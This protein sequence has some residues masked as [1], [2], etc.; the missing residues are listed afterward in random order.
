M[1]KNSHGIMKDS[2]LSVGIIQASDLKPTDFGGKWDPFCVIEVGEQE[3]E[4]TVKSNTLNP[5]WNENFNFS[6]QTGK[7][8][9]QIT[10]LDRNKDQENA[11][12]GRMQVKVSDFSDQKW[13]DLWFDL[14][15]EEDGD[16]TGGK[17]RIN[18]SLWW[19]HSKED[20]LKE[21]IYGCDDDIKVLEENLIYYDNRVQLMEIPMSEVKIKP[22]AKLGNNPKPDISTQNVSLNKSKGPDAT[23]EADLG[24]T[25]LAKLVGTVLENER[26]W[27]LMVENTSN[28]L[29]IKLGF[30]ETPW[31]ILFRISMYSYI[32]MT[33]FWWFY[34]PDFLNITVCSIM[35]Y[36]FANPMQMRQWHI[37]L[38][39]FGIFITWIFDLTWIIINT[40]HYWDEQPY[41][42]NVELGLRRFVLCVCYISFIFRIVIFIVFWKVSVEF[43]RFF[44]ED[45]ISSSF[46]NNKDQTPPKR[47]M[48]I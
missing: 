7:E 46:S 24:S 3:V 33:L 21:L 23:A 20:M 8:I 2:S 43:S 25:T 39:S 30:D 6:I 37:R 13:V 16:K 9:L 5:I 4:S 27:A 18:L 38:I 10:I 1:S 14:H 12:L 35:F 40:S 19:V 28:K 34:K 44:N 26:K 48:K 22:K 32:L 29:S 31:Y 36:L 17:G 42:G 45:N 47:I 41:D 15:S 11:F